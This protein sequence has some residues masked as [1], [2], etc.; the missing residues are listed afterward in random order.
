MKLDMKYSFRSGI[1]MQDNKDCSKLVTSQQSTF[2]AASG[3]TILFTNPLNQS[4]IY[5][6]S[7]EFE[8]K[9]EA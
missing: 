1:A 2:P 7:G 9:A 4:E 3:Y 8:V 6:E 5:S